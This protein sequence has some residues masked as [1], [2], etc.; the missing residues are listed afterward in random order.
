MLGACLTCL[1]LVASGCTNAPTSRTEYLL[2]GALVESGGT[3]PLAPAAAIGAVHVAPYLARPGIV[4]EI[5]PGE[6][7]AAQAHVWAE[8]LEDGIR[9]LLRSELARSLDAEVAAAGHAPIEVDVRI[10]RLHGSEDGRATIEA[11]YRLRR[12]P[13]RP[14]AGAQA[15]DHYRFADSESLARAGYAGLVDAERALVGRLAAAIAEAIRAL[16]AA[17]R[18]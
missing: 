14:G 8:P 9:S 13:G 6:L 16:P 12:A 4:V 10:D 17:E 3:A 18:S 15:D 7:R 1:M 11:T 2:R 5:A